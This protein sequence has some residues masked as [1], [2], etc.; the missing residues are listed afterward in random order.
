MGYK[1]KAIYCAGVDGLIGVDNKLPWDIP[2]D[3]AFF[4]QMTMGSMVLMGR[5]TL[6]SMPVK[7]KCRYSIVVSTSKD[8]THPNADMVLSSLDILPDIS[9]IAASNGFTHTGDPT[10]WVIGGKSI[11]ESLARVC[12]EIYVTRVYASTPIDGQHRVILDEKFLKH[13]VCDANPYVLTSKG[14]NHPVYARY[15]YRNILIGRK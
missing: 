10:I 3:L 6:E 2:E 12:D 1:L 4:K 5:K 13:F 15:V 9:A 11:L 7:L 8:Y 14:S